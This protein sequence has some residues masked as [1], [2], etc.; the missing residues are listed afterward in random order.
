MLVFVNGQEIEKPWHIGCPCPVISRVI[1]VHADCDELEYIRR[2]FTNIPFHTGR[3]VKWS[4]D[5]A[6][7]IYQGIKSLNPDNSWR[8]TPIHEKK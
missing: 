6:W 3:T 2:H 4:G 5:F 8:N 7:F 1:E